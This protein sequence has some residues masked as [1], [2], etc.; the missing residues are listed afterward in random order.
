M[1]HAF[2]V[3][4]KKPSLYPRLFHSLTSRI[5]AVLHF[6]FRCIIHFASIFVNGVRSVSR[7]IILHVNVQLSQYHLFKR[8][9]FPLYCLYSFDKDQL[10]TFTWVYFWAFYSITLFCLYFYH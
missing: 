4:A 9:S 5:L 1:D 10:T 7:F 2:G 3:V 6:T 8:L